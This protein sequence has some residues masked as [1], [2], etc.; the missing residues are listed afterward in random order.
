MLDW[1]RRDPHAEPTVEI[2][3]RALPVVIRRLER[4]RRMTMRLAPDGS[5]VRI[6]IPRWTRTAEALAFAQSR[7]DW[8]ARQIAALPPA[9]TL[10]HGAELPFRGRPL[11][12][13]HDPKAA[14]RPVVT[15]T[16]LHVGGPQSSLETRLLRWLRAEALDVLAVDLAEY[17]AR[18]GQPA[19]RIA[20]SNARRRWGSCAPDGSIRINWR[21]IMAP[22][23]VRRSVVAHEVAHLVHF[24]HSPAFHHCLKEL[25]EGSV[26]E[27]NRWLNTHGRALYA[28]FG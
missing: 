11:Q 6:S 26:H 15:D 17:C 4:A 18:A 9:V 3:G 22:D 23:M 2:A 16:A 19:R 13:V 8:L 20:L 1:L 21:L 25:F 14:R 5:E 12:L 28:P 10:A 27:T 7:Q 24:D